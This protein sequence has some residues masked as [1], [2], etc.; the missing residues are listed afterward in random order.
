M[1]EQLPVGSQP[2]EA[3]SRIPAG[4]SGRV[5]RIA[6]A[7]DPGWTATLNGRALTAKTVDGWA[8]GFELPAEGGTLDLTY[9]T[10]VTHT[11]WIWAQAALGV[12]LLVLALPGRRREIDDDLPEA[13]LTVAAEPVVGEGRRARRLRAAAEAEAASEGV[14]PTPDET[15]QN[16]PAQ[17]STDPYAERSE[18]QDPYA[19][20]S[21]AQDPYAQR[22]DDGLYAP[23]PQ[24]QQY[25]EWDTQQ[26]QGADYPQYQGEQQ[27][28]AADPYQQGT[29]PAYDPYGYQ[30]QQYDQNQ[31]Q[32]TQEQGQYDQS[33]DAYGQGQYSQYAPQPPYDPQAPYTAQG[34][35]DPQNPDEN[36]APARNPWPTGNASRGESE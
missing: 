9:E 2:V 8:Q 10:P 3:H 18:A 35:Y 23:V 31:G 21:A 11:A 6:D 7:A 15:G 14:E 16:I 5:L 36:P 32:Y 29:A 27:Q 26:Y 24:Q 13:D 28:A 25:G 17:R 30:Q 34:P 12:V 22:D 1:G 19:D 20:Q 33:Q 4:G